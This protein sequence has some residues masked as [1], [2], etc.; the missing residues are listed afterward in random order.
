MTITFLQPDGVPI[1][2]QAERQGSAAL[3]GAGNGRQLGARN[4]FRVGTP[5]DTLSAT[6]TVWTLKPCSAMIDPGW[7]AHQGAYGW[8]TDADITGPIT[9]AD[10]TYDR[11]D[12]VY[13]Q[14]SDSSAGDGSG[15][16]SAPV[17]YLAGT[18]SATPAEPALPPRSF[19]VG[20]IIVPKVG[21]GNPLAVLNPARFVAAGGVLPV[22]PGEQAAL[23]KY[24]GLTTSRDGIL[25]VSDGTGWNRPGPKI[26]PG[27]TSRM[28][29]TLP[30][31][32]FTSG[33]LKPIFVPGSIVVDL[34]AQGYAGINLPAFP[35]GILSIYVANGDTAASGRDKIVGLSGAPTFNDV[36]L[37]KF[38]VSVVDGAGISYGSA[39]FRVDYL[40]IGW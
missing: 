27:A 31:A 8:A 17:L 36:S 14:I 21:G 20:T 29:G 11:R 12:I 34:D 6:S 1:T 38:Y 13:I 18:P 2:A 28:G 16:K 40:A 10:A 4:G 25:E 23:T 7:T 9:A 5:L 39:P 15:A 30:A 32:A 3:N 35:N 22:T 24:A 19:L 37:S 33:N 26:I